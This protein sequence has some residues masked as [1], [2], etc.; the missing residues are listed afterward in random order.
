M[1]KLKLNEV[2]PERL[3]RSE[4]GQDAYIEHIFNI[5]GTTNRYYIELGSKD[6]VDMSNTFYLRETKNWTGF[7]VDHGYGVN[8]YINLISS[9][10]TKENIC[11]LFSNYGVPEKP[12][13]L[14]IDLDGNDYWILN[15]ILSK[16]KPR[17]IMVETN[18]RFSPLESY[19]LK[20]N[21]NWQWDGHKWYGASPFA[22]KKM[23]DKYNYTPVYIHIDDMF[24]IHND[25]LSDEDKNK[26]W[27]DVFNTPNMEIY[28]THT[29]GGRYYPIMDMDSESWIEI[30]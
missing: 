14:C 16:Y 19:S 23:A 20:Y 7:L 17:V 6:G 21:P 18:V 29:G 9:F 26:N 8:P 3:G 2:V 30:K 28:N 15:E 27:I 1:K 11:N 4:K 25:C 5:I 22:F 24:L 13:F 10:I 12:D